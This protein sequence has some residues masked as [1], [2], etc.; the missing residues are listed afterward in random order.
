MHDPR[1]AYLETQIRTATP[2][3]LRLMLVDGALRFASAA[4]EAHAKGDWERFAQDVSRSREIA[5]ELL[6]SV[7]PEPHPL[8]DTVR[9]LYAFVF[10]RLAEAQ[11]L[12]DAGKLEEALQVLA[13]ERET[14]QQL[15]ELTPESPVPSDNQSPHEIAAPSFV[16][17]PQAST[18]SLDA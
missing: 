4:I 10:R 16:T 5:S 7:R 8:N 1:A 3:K 6:A 14:W 17:S 13:E 12:R 11:L 15:C 9:A 18:L 2:Q